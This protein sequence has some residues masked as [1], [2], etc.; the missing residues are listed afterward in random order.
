MLLNSKDGS[1][2]WSRHAS[3]A[4]IS[5]TT[6][7]YNEH[8]AS[9]FE[10]SEDSEESVSEEHPNRPGN[11]Q[12]I[13]LALNRHVNEGMTLVDALDHSEIEASDP[14]TLSRWKNKYGAESWT[15][16]VE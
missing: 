6:A 13:Q 10:I 9:E 3:Y 14:S 1:D 12:A 11:W 15:P 16:E 8:Q 4:G 7:T 5:D 2:E